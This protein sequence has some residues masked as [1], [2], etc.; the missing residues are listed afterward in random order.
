MSKYFKSKPH[1]KPR[2]NCIVLYDFIG[3]KLNFMEFLN[4]CGREEEY[5]KMKEQKDK[6]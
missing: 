1:T 6:E 2:N 3:G 5:C 4:W